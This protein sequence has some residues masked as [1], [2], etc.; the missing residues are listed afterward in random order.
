[1]KTNVL[2]LAITLTLGII[3]AGSMLMPVITDAQTNIGPAATMTNEKPA[4]ANYNYTLWDGADISFEYSSTESSSTYTI[5]DETFSLIS[6]EQRIILASNDFAT[7]SGGNSELFILNS[8]FVGSTTQY[9]NS[10]FSFVIENKEYTLEIGGQT[11]T[12][13]VDW[14]VYASDDGNAGLIQLKTPSAPF[15]TSNAND[16]VI[17]GNIYTTGDNDTFYSYYKG[18]LTVNEAYADESSVT[19]TKTEVSGYTDI[20][21]TTISVN[22]G[23]ESFTPFFILAPEKATGHEASGAAYSLLGAIPIIVIIGLVLAAT[24]AIV[25][26]RND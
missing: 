8:Q 11:Y 5:N 3:L 15:Y 14:L 23:D 6:S 4:G 22:V 2:T 19:I 12:G 10:D 20:Y 16:L 25:V 18:Q 24:A 13:H 7:R 21:S 1:M 17:L 26:K 9:N